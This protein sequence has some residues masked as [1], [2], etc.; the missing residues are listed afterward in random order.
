MNRKL[1]LF[2]IIALV[3][4]TLMSPW[5][6]GSDGNVE[7]QE[8]IKIT[9]MSGRTVYVPR[10]IKKVVGIEAGSLR[11]I[12]YLNDTEKVVGIE[13]FEK[14]D[15]TGRP[16]I[17]AHPELLDRPSIGPIHGGTPEL[18][19]SREPDVV[20]WTY[21]TAGKADDL[22]QKIGIP[23]IVLDYGDL[24]HNRS[25]FYESLNLMGNVLGSEDRV[26]ELVSFIDDTI[27]DLNERTE[28]I[29][30]ENKPRVYVG[31]VGYRGAHGIVSTEPAYEPF[32]FVNARNVA[33]G[34]GVEHA[35]VDKEKLIQWD[36][37][38]IFVDEGG[39][40]LVKND[41]EGVEYGSMSA[42]KNREIYS[43]LPYNYYTANFGILLAN[44][45]YIGKVLYPHRFDDIDPENKADEIFN[46]FVGESVYEVIEENLGGFKRFDF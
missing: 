6:L 17:V 33:S 16:Y 2:P 7:G 45:Y 1:L 28:N 39:Y 14:R 46:K 35:M 44:S 29:S 24:G 13:D 32:S 3:L 26:E 30:R 21:T 38:I 8:K 12:A 37:D 23:V 9:D 15:Q 27:E 41:L 11:L 22:Q 10:E 34:L 43:L 31:G 20:F 40:S 19:A 18:I 5:L 42:V 25:N 36:P 4:V